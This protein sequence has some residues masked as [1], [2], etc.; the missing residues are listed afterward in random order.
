MYL[1]DWSALCRLKYQT[2]S[3]RICNRMW[4][5][6]S[7]Y[8]W[9]G[10]SFQRCCG[11]SFRYVIFLYKYIQNDTYLVNF[12]LSGHLWGTIFLPLRYKKLWKG[13]LKH[14]LPTQISDSIWK[15]L[16]QNAVGII[17]IFLMGIQFSA[18]SW[19]FFQACYFSLQIYSE[20]HTWS[21]FNWYDTR[22][23]DHL[24]DTVF[25]PLGYRKYIFDGDS[26]FSDVWEFL[27]ACFYYF[28]LLFNSCP[29]RKSSHLWR[30]IFSPL[31]YGRLCK[32]EL[33]GMITFATK[34]G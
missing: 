23:S 5:G 22:K 9:W 3:E 31:W 11:S 28:C 18:M 1:A 19:A 24:W 4:L 21:I 33:F 17:C 32:Q 14:P 10:F 30:P 6:S 20:W 16:L 29:N 26:G 34:C 2:P 25:L 15:N 7:V 8:F 27:Q 12:Q 13:W